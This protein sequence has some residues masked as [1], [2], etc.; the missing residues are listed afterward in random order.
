MNDNDLLQEWAEHNRARTAR[1]HP[2]QPTYDDT[3]F[4][5]EPRSDEHWEALGYR[6][7]GYH[8]EQP[9]PILIPEWMTAEIGDGVTPG[10]RDQCRYCG[11]E[12]CSH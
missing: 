3:Q 4:V 11:V 1:R 6:W 2:D 7:T 12:E 5:S 10:Q 8:W 9:W